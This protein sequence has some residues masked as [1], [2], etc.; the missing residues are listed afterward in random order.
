MEAHLDLLGAR[1]DILY[2]DR[3]DGRIDP[4]TYDSKAQEI[5]AEQSCT[6]A[7]IAECRSGTLPPAAEALGLMSFTSR[8]AEL[9]Q[10][11]TGSEKPDCSGWSWGRRPG[12]PESC[13]CAS[14]SLLSNCDYRTP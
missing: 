9:F 13:G 14:A 5:R 11:Q 8:A 4:S 3:L 1:L 7:I 10:Q 2:D 12:K 6:Q